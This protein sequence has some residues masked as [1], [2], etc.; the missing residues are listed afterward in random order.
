MTEKKNKKFMIRAAQLARENV[1]LGLGGPFGAVVV[2][3]DKIIGSGSNK[4]TTDNDPTAHAEVVAI[5]EACL[6]LNTFKL[7]GC[8]IYCSCEPCPMCLAAIIWARIGRVFYANSRWDAA[9][10]G[11][12]DLK[13]YE[14]L[15]R[16]V[17]D[18]NVPM[19]HLPEP[20]AELAF[21]KWEKKSDKVSY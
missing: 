12:D 17:T 21:E 16:A 9:R 20:I 5:R 11:F 19:V 18:R 8:E 2:K 7:T 3:D 4:V 15:G 13:I 1:Q 6:N 10:I 14:E